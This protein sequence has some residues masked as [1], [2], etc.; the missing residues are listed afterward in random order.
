MSGLY[1]TPL[2]ATIMFIAAVMAGYQYRRVWKTEGPAWQ[3]WLY[4]LIAAICLLTLGFLPMKA[5]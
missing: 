4:G 2:P 1:L 3:L 5:G